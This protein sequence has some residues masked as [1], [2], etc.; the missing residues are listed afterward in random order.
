MFPLR[1]EGSTRALWRAGGLP[2]EYGHCAHEKHVGR[3]RVLVIKAMLCV[4]V[5]V[6]E[7]GTVDFT[8]VMSSTILFVMPVSTKGR[9]GSAAAFVVAYVCVT[10]KRE[11]TCN[12][13]F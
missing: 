3:E 5:W 4:Y 1:V 7:R 9:R 12:P 13:I 8:H 10:D 2:L 6:E 11:Q